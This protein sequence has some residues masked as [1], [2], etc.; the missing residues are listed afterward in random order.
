MASGD[1][2][3]SSYSY[4]TAETGYTEFQRNI[5]MGWLLSITVT[6]I[7]ISSSLPPVQQTRG[8]KPC[9]PSSRNEDA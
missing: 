3:I 9:E 5:S 1:M 6:Y 4:V 2:L 7:G 8:I